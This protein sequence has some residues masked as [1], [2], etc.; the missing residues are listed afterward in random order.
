MSADF[1]ICI[2]VPLNSFGTKS[3]PYWLL[4]CQKNSAWFFN[5]FVDVFEQKSIRNAL[6][7]HYGLLPPH[8]DY[9]TSPNFFAQASPINM[10]IMTRDYT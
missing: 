1:Q 7:L 8:H 9:K 10:T 2:S 3:L 6:S 4:I 5:A